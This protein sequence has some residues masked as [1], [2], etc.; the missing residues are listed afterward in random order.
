MMKYAFSNFKNTIDT[1]VDVDEE[2]MNTEA[3]G[4][5]VRKQA[6]MQVT[7]PSTLVDEPHKAKQSRRLTRSAQKETVG[8]GSLRSQ[9][10]KVG[11]VRGRSSDQAET[12][13]SKVCKRGG[14]SDRA[15]GLYGGIDPPSFDLGI[16]PAARPTL[17]KRD[18]KLS[19]KLR[20]PYVA[21]AVTFDITVDERK[22]QDWIMRGIGG[23][24]E[25]VFVTRYGRTIT[26]QAMQY[27]ATQSVV[28]REMNYTM[29]EQTLDVH[30]RYEVFKNN[31][32]CWTNNDRELISMRNLGMVFFPIVEDSLYYLIVFNLKRPSIIVIDFKYRDGN[33]DEIYGHST[34][35]LEQI[36]TRW[37]SHETSVDCGVIMMRNM[38]TYFGVDGG[39]WESGLYK[40]STKQKR[41][42][43]DLR[44]KYCSK[45][46]LS[47]ENIR[48][49]AI[50]TDVERFI[51]MET[52]Y[53]AKRTR[54]ATRIGPGKVKAIRETVED[55]GFEVI[56]FTEQDIAVC[57][58]R[59]K[60]MACPSCSESV[61]RALSM[62]EGVKKAVVGLALEEAKI[63]YDPNV[64]N[65]DHIIE[66]VEDA[67]FGADLIGSGNDG[68]K[69]HIKIEGIT[70][71]EDM[72]AVKSY[73]ES[74]AGV[75]H[76]EIDMEEYKVAVSYDPDM[77]GPRSLIFFIQ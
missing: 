20:S 67:G 37:Q 49:T 75:N 36:R 53:N 61:E 9:V 64:F 39:K 29:R 16:S 74:L 48:K 63:D 34:V 19:F 14:S 73:L 32:S 43:R 62:V 18:L 66:A 28:C 58:L 76:V 38:E 12:R 44:S 27:L 55:A 60:G 10:E 6:V 71:P 68:N 13:T 33:I 40:E 11:I 70:S 30:H 65:T 3:T 8:I 47:E 25:P 26:Q 15:I 50:I 54:R 31:I 77:T 45:I 46:I 22:L 21:R 56:E 59:I 7:N 72:T 42:L 17:S 57:R 35:V 23:I 51:A 41:Q 4:R 2:P 24:L 5:L 69:V 52:S 1:S